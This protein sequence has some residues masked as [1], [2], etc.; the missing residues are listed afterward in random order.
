V[1]THS[2]NDMAKYTEAVL[3]TAVEQS[4][5]V[6]GV[7]RGLGLV[8]AGGTHSHVSRLIK[9]YGIDTSHF[10]GQGWRQNRTFPNTRSPEELLQLLPEG[11]PRTNG[12]RLRRALIATG[13]PYICTMCG[14]TGEWL[15]SQLVLQVDHINGNYLDNRPSS[16]RF[17]CPN[18]HT[19]C[20][21]HS[22]RNKKLLRER[23]RDGP[24]PR[25]ELRPSRPYD[26]D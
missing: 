6:A 17:L 12:Q 1:V 8:P 18:C 2:V 21:T 15:A 9:R 13:R 7:L 23:R 11:S 14:N 16:L 25:A 5:S 10:T 19:Q 22:G 20:P 4:S 26:D 24:P 3:R